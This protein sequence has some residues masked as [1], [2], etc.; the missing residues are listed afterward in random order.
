MW[1]P[2]DPATVNYALNLGLSLTQASSWAK[3]IRRFGE[4]AHQLNGRP[5]A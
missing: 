2:D 5:K 4:L 3:I 1:L